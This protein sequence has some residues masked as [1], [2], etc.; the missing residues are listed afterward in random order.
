MLKN[1]LVRLLI[2]GTV[3]GLLGLIL[4][5][6]LTITKPVEAE[7]PVM[8]KDTLCPQAQTLTD[9]RLADKNFSL[10]ETS[11]YKCHLYNES[12]DASLLPREFIILRDKI[13]ERES[14]WIKD[15][16]GDHGSAYS[17]A[18]YHEPTFEEMKIRANMPWLQYR[19]PEDQLTLLAWAYNEGPREM[20]H[21]TTWR[22]LVGA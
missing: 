11:I 5:A 9:Y 10:E 2:V 15:I 18:Q 17:F 1:K 13:V 21:W 4:G 8:E 6:S 12:L 7:A 22:R 19:N 14:S 20:R 3:K 16:Y